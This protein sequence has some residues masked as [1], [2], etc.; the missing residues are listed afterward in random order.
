MIKKGDYLQHCNHAWS[1]ET[2]EQQVNVLPEYYYISKVENS[3]LRVK[4][5]DKPAAGS[6]IHCVNDIKHYSVYAD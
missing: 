6:I 4:K 1:K 5:V 2:T 3:V